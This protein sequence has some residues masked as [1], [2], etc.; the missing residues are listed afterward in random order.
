MKIGSKIIQSLVAVDVD[1]L[2][3]YH[4]DAVTFN[5]RT[6]KLTRLNI[7]GL[8]R[9]QDSDGVVCLCDPADQPLDRPPPSAIDISG[10]RKL[11][12]DELGKGF[13]FNNLTFAL[14]ITGGNLVISYKNQKI[15]E[16]PV[17]LL[18]QCED[19]EPDERMETLPFFEDRIGSLSVAL[20]TAYGHTAR[21]K[22][23]A[24]YP[25]IRVT[26]DITGWLCE[27]L[28]SSPDGSSDDP[29]AVLKFLLTEA[30][31]K[32]VLNDFIKMVSLPVDDVETIVDT[33]FLEYIRYCGVSAGYRTSIWNGMVAVYQHFNG[34]L[35]DEKIIALIE[36]RFEK[37]EFKEFQDYD[38]IPTSAVS[39][40]IHLT[41]LFREE[42]TDCRREL[43]IAMLCFGLTYGEF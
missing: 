17:Y 35:D 31:D 29:L 15:Y 40:L 33:L 6:N 26:Q 8:L 16:E 23:S 11:N 12:Q 20:K 24:T 39:T 5:F 10:F 19:D 2:P 42:A 43:A 9:S 32:S 27:Q 28:E 14:E 37:N 41:D 36:K 18:F 4:K 13:H 21:L 22:S 1:A 30:G 38:I 3:L 34:D 7:P 25:A